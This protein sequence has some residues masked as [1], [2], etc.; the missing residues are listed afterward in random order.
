MKYEMKCDY[1]TISVLP[2]SSGLTPE[3]L[4]EMAMKA[5]MIEDW[6]NFFE[7]KTSNRSYAYIYRYSNVSIKIAH[8]GNYYKNGICFE[9]SGQGID[10]YENYLSCHKNVNLRT[11]LNRFR[12][13]YKYNVKT[14]CSRFDVAID[15]N[16]YD[17]ELPLLDLELIEETLKSRAFVSKFRRGEPKV[18]SSELTSMFFVQPEEIDSSLP[19]QI[20]KS[21]N[22]SSGR[23]GTT[24]YLGKRKSNSFVRFYD[25]LAEREVKGDKE[26]P[27]NLKSW[28]RFEIEFKKKNASSVFAAFLDCENDKEFSKYMSRVSFE[29]IRFVDKDRSR[30]YNATVCDWWLKFLDSMSDTGMIINKLSQ[31]QYIRSR[32]YVKKNLIALLSALN[33]CDDKFIDEVLE[34]GQHVITKT[35]QRIIQDFNAL[36]VLSEYDQKKEFEKAEHVQTGEEFWRLFTSEDSSAFGERMF[37]KQLEVF[38]KDV[39]VVNDYSDCG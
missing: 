24:I 35:K 22:F 33:E 7:Y 5:L 18:E 37:K 6:W 9:F 38:N 11:A 30:L 29:L 8:P 19:L 10:Y 26:I 12:L 2:G 14:K 28:T 36:S 4:L 17:D 25:K 13:L 34:D 3:Q 31:N 23:I 20:Y 32:K 15:E 27:E 21:E 1:L 16:C 39:G